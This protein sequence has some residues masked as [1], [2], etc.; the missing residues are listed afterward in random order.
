MTLDFLKI[1]SMLCVF[2][3]SLMSVVHKLVSAPMKLGTAVLY[4]FLFSLSAQEAIAG[5]GDCGDHS[6][7]SAGPGLPT[8]PQHDSQ[9]K[10]HF[11]QLLFSSRNS[12]YPVL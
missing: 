9:V 6:W 11:P 10:S 8:L 5:N 3:S 2:I 1:N 4:F 7:C 12:V